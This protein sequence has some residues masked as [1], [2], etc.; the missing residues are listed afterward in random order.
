MSPSGATDPLGMAEVD[1][2]RTAV[3]A[4]DD[5]LTADTGIGDAFDPLEAGL[6][7]SALVF[8]FD[9][10]AAFARGLAGCF[11]FAAAYESMFDK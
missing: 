10:D 7:S 8:A 6:R 5:F 4:A 11:G 1:L 2:D 3:A 9:L